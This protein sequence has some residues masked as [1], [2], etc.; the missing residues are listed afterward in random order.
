MKLICTQEN[1]KK[2]ILNCERIVSKQNTL[3]I[4]NNILIE[5]INGELRIKATNLEMGVVAK[6][7]AKIEDEGKITIPA[8]I[9]SIFINNLKDGGNLHIEADEQNLKIKT[10][11]SK[12]LIKGLSANDFPLIP[13]RNI[14]PQ[15]ILPGVVLSNIINKIMISVANVDTRQELTGI[16]VILNEKEILFASTDSFRLSESRLELKKENIN[17]DA[18]LALVEK[19]NTLIIPAVTMIEVARIISNNSN[20]VVEIAI[21]EG[22]IFFN[23]HETLLVSRLINGKYP[24][25]K[26][27]MPVEFKTRIVMDRDIIQGAV[28]TASLFS[29]G[30][31]SE[32]ALKINAEEGKT[33]IEARSVEAGENTTELNLD[34][35]GP[36][37]EVVFNA[38]YLLDGI[39]ILET[40]KVAILVNSGT[41]PVVLREINEENGKILTNYTYIVM[42][43]KN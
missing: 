26:H 31:T 23:I 10:E 14:E 13:Q 4:L 7:S 11:A 6:I 25:Y 17:K 30:K 20:S 40:S 2:A 3:P 22:Q 38:K 42:P 35:V 1:F 41:S 37:Q 9:L 39:N 15:I 12:T 24:E 8:K 33:I 34:A 29:P 18:Y 36:N 19:N 32:V 5:A 28:K 21:E 27:I 43:I 16:N